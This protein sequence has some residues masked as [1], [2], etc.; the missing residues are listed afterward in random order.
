[1]AHTQPREYAN[2]IGREIIPT[3][4][5]I[6]YIPLDWKP[7]HVL[8]FISQRKLPLPSDL[9]CLYD[10]YSVFRG[11][12][13]ATFASTGES[14]R[15]I[16]DL[17]NYRVSGRTLHVQFRRKS[18]KAVAAEKEDVQPKH[19]SHTDVPDQ[20][21]SIPQT[22]ASGATRPTREQ[23]PPCD[24]YHLLM[25][26]QTNPVE[27]E[28]LRWFLAQTGEYQGAVNEFARSRARETGAG[29]HG[30]I[31][32]DGTILEERPPTPGEEMQVAEMEGHFG[33]MPEGL[34]V[35]QSSCSVKAN[36]VEQMWLSAG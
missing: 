4:V 6:K 13:F 30:W 36:T 28:K 2:N 17:H 11:M 33:L 18:L 10:D 27:K 32:E 19:H 31:A 14:R 16:Q 20:A 1:M 5:M 35:G 21:D 3:A 26:Y 22:K 7:D 12:A 9:K 34:R 15:V 8:R 25:S 24:S 23:T 29:L